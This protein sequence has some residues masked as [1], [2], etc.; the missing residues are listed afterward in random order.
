MVFKQCDELNHEKKSLQCNNRKKKRD[1]KLK[2]L[3]KVV[4]NYKK[5]A[6]T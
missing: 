6:S 4:K 1:K 3:Q 2:Y 5:K